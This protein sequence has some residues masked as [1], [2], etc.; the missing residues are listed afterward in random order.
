MSFLKNFFAK[1]TQAN[2]SK[3]ID[4][5]PENTA[6]ENWAQSKEQ[7][8]PFC[9]VI[10]KDLDDIK[11]FR[12]N[13]DDFDNDAAAILE[14][15]QSKLTELASL[16]PSFE[17][18]LITYEAKT[19]REVDGQKI[20]GTDVLMSKVYTGDLILNGGTFLVEFTHNNYDNIAINLE[21]LQF[22]TP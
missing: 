8:I 2:D 12:V 16:E 5:S 18:G 11:T 1:P 14:F 9:S 6:I 22:L 13:P 4:Q 7:L 17:A 20:F 19:S 3:P 10:F 21:T 15:H